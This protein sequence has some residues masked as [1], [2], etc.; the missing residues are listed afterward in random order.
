MR[1]ARSTAHRHGATPERRGGR[2]FFDQAITQQLANHFA[3]C[4][5]L[6]NIG[7]KPKVSAPP[8]FSHSRSLR[9]LCEFCQVLRSS[10]RT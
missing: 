2:D 7:G 4:A 3:G 8:S 6:E 9:G 10:V 1:S 5:A